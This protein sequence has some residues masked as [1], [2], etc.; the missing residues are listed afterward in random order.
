MRILHTADWHLGKRLMD[1]SRLPEQHEVMAEICEV[2]DREEVDAVIVAGDL[3]DTYNPG[4]E[5]MELLYRTLKRLSREGQRPVIAIAGNHDSADRIEA[6]DPLARECGILFAGYPG[7]HIPA[8]TLDTG[9]EVSHSEPGFVEVRVPGI[10]YP[11][12]LLLTPYANEVTMRRYLGEE[13]REEALRQVLAERWQHL[14]DRYCDDLGVNMLTAHLY[15][16][17]KGGAEPEEPDDE[18]PI[19]H[20]GGAQ[21]IYTENFPKNMQYVALGHLHRYQTVDKEPCPVV[22]SSSPLSYSFSEAGQQKYVAI[23]DV[24]P[25]KEAEVRRVALEKGRKL[26]RKRFESTEEAV[27]WLTANEQ[28]FV[29]LTLVTET[30]LAAKTKKQLYNVHDGIVSLIPEVTG[31]QDP[32]QARGKVMPDMNRDIRDLFKSYFEHKKGQEP[33]EDLMQLFNEILEAQR[34]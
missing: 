27:E 20:M 16:M 8:F 30:Y 7:S 5:A 21:A 3:F 6:P 28:T 34:S 12:R 29:E 23:I 17:K 1:Y 11:M 2:A 4:N 31:E 32:M 22:Y 25:G 15:V 33:N 9:L 18:K 14:A 19:L 10:G 24:E 13:D 26:I